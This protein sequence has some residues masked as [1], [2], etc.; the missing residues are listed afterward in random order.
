MYRDRILISDSRI[1]FESNFSAW[2][3]VQQRWT[4]PLISVLKRPWQMVGS[5]R[6]TINLEGGLTERATFADDCQSGIGEHS[7]SGVS[8]QV[9]WTRAP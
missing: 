2:D 7:A 4:P 8:Y 9:T 1:I 6:I 3:S 5:G